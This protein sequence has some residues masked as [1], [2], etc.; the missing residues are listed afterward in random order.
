M[1]QLAEHLSSDIAECI[2]RDGVVLQVHRD[3]RGGVISNITKRSS[4]TT[5]AAPGGSSVIIHWTPNG[6][7]RITVEVER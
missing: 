5:Y 6:R 7:I 2:A 4:G 1:P 3:E